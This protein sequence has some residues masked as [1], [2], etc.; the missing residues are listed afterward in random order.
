MILDICML[1]SIGVVNTKHDFPIAILPLVY[2]LK[3]S[4]ALFL[5]RLTV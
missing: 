1:W 4:E 2:D 5:P 3:R